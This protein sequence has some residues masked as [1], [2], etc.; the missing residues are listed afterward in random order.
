MTREEMAAWADTLC[1]G[2]DFSA[3]A[4][5]CVADELR[6]TCEY[7]ETEDGEYWD[8]ACGHQL[9]FE[10]GPPSKSGCKFCGRCGGVLVEV[11][12]VEPEEES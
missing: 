3:Y 6:R 4:A 8:T 1:V 9:V 7:R 11:S 12:Y 5:E 2:G 10:Y